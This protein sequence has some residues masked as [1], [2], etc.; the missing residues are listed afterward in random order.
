MPRS[1][2]LSV[3]WSEDGKRFEIVADLPWAADGEALKL[4]QAAKQAVVTFRLPKR[5]AFA[6]VDEDDNLGEFNEHTWSVAI[7]QLTTGQSWMVN[8][9][10]V[11]KSKATKFEVQQLNNNVGVRK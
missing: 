9:G 10:F 2:L 5:K 1:E 4:D 3:N 8:Y 6:R 7:P 11:S